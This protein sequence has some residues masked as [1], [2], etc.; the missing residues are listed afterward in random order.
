MRKEKF[1]KTFEMKIDRGG[2]AKEKKKHS[3]C[4][5]FLPSSFMEIV[6]VLPLVPQINPTIKLLSSIDL[7][8]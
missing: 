2:S 3:T 4:D 7:H 1:R 5:E 8:F 6:G